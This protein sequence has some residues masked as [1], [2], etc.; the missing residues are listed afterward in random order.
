[1]PFVPHVLVMRPRARLCLHKNSTPIKQNKRVNLATRCNH[2]FLSSPQPP[3]AQHEIG[4][5]PEALPISKQA[6]RLTSSTAKSAVAGSCYLPKYWIVLIKIASHQ[7]ISKVGNQMSGL[8]QPGA[9]KCFVSN[10]TP[11]LV[12]EKKWRINDCLLWL[13]WWQ[14]PVCTKMSDVVK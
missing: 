2:P 9:T 4:P 13:E 5:R 7:N 14:L 3:A 6:T 1:M 11:L 8:I 10:G 12:M